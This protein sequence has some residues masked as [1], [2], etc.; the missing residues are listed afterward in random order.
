MLP[1]YPQVN[2]ENAIAGASFVPSPSSRDIEAT[3]ASKGL[4]IPA[5]TRGLSLSFSI[6]SGD[7]ETDCS[8]VLVGLRFGLKS[9]A[10]GFGGGLSKPGCSSSRALLRFG[11]C[12]GRG[13][14]T[15]ALPCEL[16]CPGLGMRIDRMDDGFVHAPEITGVFFSGTDDREV[17]GGKS[18]D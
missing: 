18:V 5:S 11:L 8:L 3:L 6:L 13:W 17:R 9:S 1:R 16:A 4:V 10:A 14:C 12:P 2:I 15:R 7:R